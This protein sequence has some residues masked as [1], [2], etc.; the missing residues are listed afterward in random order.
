M[1]CLSKKNDGLSIKLQVSSNEPNSQSSFGDSSLINLNRIQWYHLLIWWKPCTLSSMV[2]STS[3]IQL[4]QHFMPQAISVASLA[5][6][7][8][9]SE[10][11]HLGEMALHATIVSLSM[12]NPMSMVP[13]DSRW[14]GSFCSSHFCMAAKSTC[15]HSFNG[16]PSWVPDP[17]KIQAVGWLSQILG[18]MSPLML[19]SSILTVSFAPFISC[20]SQ[21]PLVLSTG[22]SQCTPHLI[23]SSFSTL[24]D[25]LTIMPLNP[26]EAGML[27]I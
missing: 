8:N 15:V 19:W 22:L 17:T 5:C 3:S 23:H 11:Y 25:L 7:V 4:S 20:P 2:K 10:Q 6:V 24:I 13:R 21:G 26:C 14:P 9:T 1:G 16:I 27:T 12:P 18:M